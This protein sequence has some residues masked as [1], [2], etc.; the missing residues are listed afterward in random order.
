M[1]PYPLLPGSGNMGLSFSV[2]S[3]AANTLA[4]NQSIA[5][6]GLTT[7]PKIMILYGSRLLSPGFASDSLQAFGAATSPTEV[8]AIAGSAND[9]SNP[10]V[11][12]RF[13]VTDHCYVLPGSLA[14][15]AADATATFVSFDADSGS[16]AGFTINW[17][18]AP[19]AAV[20][21]N[22]VLI[23]GTDIT[24][25][26]AGNVTLTTASGSQAFTDPGFQPDFLLLAETLLTTASV[27]GTSNQ[28]GMIGFAD[29]TSSEQS[30]AWMSQTGQ[31]TTN[32]ASGERTEIVQGITL[33][34]SYDHEAELA[35]LDASGFTLNVTDASAANRLIGYLAVKGGRWKAFADTQ[36]TS[37][38]TKATTGIGFQPQGVVL[39][40]VN[41]TAQATVGDGMSISLGASDGTNERSM[42]W[43]D[44]DAQTGAQAKQSWSNTKA[45]QLNTGP[46]T[47]N[48]EAG[49]SSFDADGFTLNWTAAD[50]TA[51]EFVGFAVG[52]N[53][54]SV[55]TPMTTLLLGV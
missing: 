12:V 13:I 18:D 51:R 50:A 48:A 41:R 49:V 24:S 22:Y 20:I 36:R 43:E 14:G 1:S 9:G 17:D 3:F 25:A 10:S 55:V 27:T 5:H 21:V 6:A 16:G 31:A 33:T 46:S 37:P 38:G 4:G 30:V 8:W 7:T 40:S 11:T 26:K 44:K 53:V 23:G 28:V 34:S 15:T 52:V 35:S 47:T 45:V 29:S 54:A 2:G 42:W 19:S 39:A 32:T